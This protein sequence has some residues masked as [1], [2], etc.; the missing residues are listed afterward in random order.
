[1]CLYYVA[2]SYSASIFQIHVVGLRQPPVLLERISAEP[3]H[4]VKNFELGD[5]T[6]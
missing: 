4:L 6:S 1:M 5:T 2:G 3:G